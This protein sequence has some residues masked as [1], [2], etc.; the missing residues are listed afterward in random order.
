MPNN[1]DKN[2]F[3]IQEAMEFLKFAE[4]FVNAEYDDPGRVGLK[5]SGYGFTGKLHQEFMKTDRSKEAAEKILER[6]VRENLERYKRVFPNW[7]TLPDN[8]KQSLLIVGHGR[9]YFHNY[10]TT[11]SSYDKQLTEAV[12][13]E[14]WNKAVD[15]LR[16]GLN[17]DNIKD[18]LRRRYN[19]IGHLMLTGERLPDV[20]SHNLNYIGE[21][22]E[23]NPAKPKSIEEL[24]AQVARIA[25]M[26]TA[27]LV[28]G[29]QGGEGMDTPISPQQPGIDITEIKGPYGDPSQVI[30]PVS[31]EELLSEIISNPAPYSSTPLVGLSPEI[32]AYQNITNS[33]GQR[34]SLQ[35]VSFYAYGGYAPNLYALGG[36]DY[37]L[38]GI[39]QSVAPL[40]MDV[41]PLDVS[42]LKAPTIPKATSS[43]GSKIMGNIGGIASG[44]AGIAT[45]A[46]GA[47][48]IKDTSGIENNIQAQSQQTS[49]AMDTTSLLNEWNS[50]TPMDHVSASS[51]RAGNTAT[52]MLGGIGSGAGAGAIFGPVGGAIGAGIG[53]IGGLIGGLFGSSKAKRKAAQLNRQIDRANNQV[54]HNFM[55]RAD[56]IDNIIDDS[57]ERGF[58]AYGGP[59]NNRELGFQEF[60]S[61]G[62]HEQNPNQ[63]VPIGIGANGEPNM[64]EQGETKYNNYIFS[65]RIKVKDKR[66]LQEAGINSKFVGKTMSQI[67][68]K[69]KKEAEE[70]P[71]DPISRRG[72]E[73][74]MAKLK[75]L[76]EAYKQQKA[77]EEQIRIQSILQAN[78]ELQRLALAQAQQQNAMQEQAIMDQID[79]MVLQ[80]MQ[81]D[82]EGPR[83]IQNI[84][85]VTEEESK[86]ELLDSLKSRLEVN[87]FDEGGFVDDPEPEFDY[88][89]F[90]NLKWRPTPIHP[91]NAN[92]ISFA[93]GQRV[94]T[95]PHNL[96]GI[97]KSPFP[98]FDY[99]KTMSLLESP[100]LERLNE[101]ITKYNDANPKIKDNLPWYKEQ[102]NLRYVPALGSAIGVATDIL[103][104]TNKPN[105]DIS[106][107][108]QGIV[109]PGQ[110]NPRYLGQY[111]SFRPMDINYQANQ[112]AKQAGAT[113]RGLMNASAGNIASAQAG[114]LSSDMNSQTQLGQLYMQADQYNQQMR[115]RAL[116]FNRETDK[117]N[118]QLALQAFQSK[119][120]NQQL[121]LQAAMQRAQLMAQER[122]IANQGRSANL[123]NLFNSLGDIGREAF[124]R[125][126]I[127]SSPYM[128]YG[129]NNS[130]YTSYKKDPKSTQKKEEK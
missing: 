2:K 61:G 59:I 88:S 42:S 60:N 47:A 112:L 21:N 68:K 63:G 111:M 38:P 92:N 32:Q 69:L 93:S 23:Y 114:L 115:E 7:E 26:N 125:N 97:N 74:S 76:Q 57:L 27:N 4:G 5:A 45:S 106:N 98:R 49:S 107:S 95:N 122:A 53:A 82:Q 51:L 113:R 52:G 39:Q 24:N 117:A 103:G 18:G 110:Y 87:R 16:W 6:T 123:T 55:N 50:F 22:G 70:R 94:A 100:V 62:T 83:D 46:L 33:L 121:L 41:K 54:Q 67:S 9:P 13:S 15:A 3:N 43:I 28:E 8:I 65:N 71:N 64:V 91:Y 130:G 72:L 37:N 118:E 79:P 14:D 104:L 75:A 80:Q 56:S 11:K 99:N 12:L 73:A 116:G 20:Y 25:A 44:V 120:T 34:T 48:K 101:E 126:M 31:A 102:A 124:T 96:T 40:K 17:Q 129:I 84:Q 1:I 85:P 105:Y 30:T 127:N 89:Y 77:I 19:A 66:Q 58:Y 86:K 29:Q 81:M 35:P 119:Q 90:P 10:K 128:L 78:P 36:L 109:T 108:L